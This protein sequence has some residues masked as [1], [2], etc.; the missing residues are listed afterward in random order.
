MI[1][2]LG[3][4]HIGANRRNKMYAQKIRESWAYIVKDIARIHRE[5]FGDEDAITYV[6]AGDLWDS[7]NPRP[8]DLLWVK[9]TLNFV[10]ANNPNEIRFILIPGNHDRVGLDGVCPASIFKEEYEKSLYSAESY[11]IIEELRRDFF[12]SY[13]SYTEANTRLYLIPYSGMLL[14]DLLEVKELVE[15]DN[16]NGNKILVSHFTTIDQNKYAGIVEEDAHVFDPFD[17]IVTGDCHIC[18]DRGRF[19]TTGSSYM[20]NVDELYSKNCIPSY[21][22]VDPETGSVSRHTYTEMKPVIINSEDEAIDDNTV[23]LIVSDD[24]ISVSKPNVFVKYRL[25]N[26]LVEGDN[27]VDDMVEIGNINK[28]KIFNV[29]FPELS[30]N[31]RRLLRMYANSEIQLVDVITGN[32]MQIINKTRDE[33]LISEVELDAEMEGLL[34]RNE[35]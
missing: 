33:H 27:S 35:F 23:Y 15:N 10:R 11:T 29:M 21:V 7:D 19:H 25:A 13:N 5:R 31:E 22:E 2:I 20:F 24:A 1:Y 16:F 34:D 14:A 17:S 4:N 26:T 30:D 32:M 9:D 28:D 12:I 3:D 6:F 8:N 18:Y